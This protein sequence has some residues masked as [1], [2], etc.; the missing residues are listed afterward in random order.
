MTT[1]R[2]G[3]T[4]VEALVALFV[5]AIGMI[6]LM[7][8]FP[9][10]A[11]QMGQAL[12]D[13]RSS[14]LAVQADAKV[15]TYWRGLLDGTLT[16]SGT[17]T[18]MT[19]FSNPGNGN[20]AVGSNAPPTIL[21]S[22]PGNIEPSYPVFLD[23]IGVSAW[24][25]NLQYV[26]KV[27]QLAQLPRRTFAAW[28]FS[29]SSSTASVVR[30]AGL[31]DDLSYGDGGVATLTDP[32]SG[33]NLTP[34]IERQGRYNWLA[35]VQRPDNSNPGVA[36]LKI[37]VFDG[38]APGY[39]A[40][41]SETVYNKANNTGNLDVWVTPGSTSLTLFYSGARPAVTKGRWIMDAT[42][43]DANNTTLVMTGG[44]VQNPTTGGPYNLNLRNANFY[45]VV[46]VND[47]TPNQLDIEIQTPF[48]LSRDPQGNSSQNALPYSAT[49]VV[50][51]GV[52]EVFDR[53]LL[54][55]K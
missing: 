37:V 26:D 46:S 33:T 44:T 8:L 7:T 18:L 6:C 42:L 53:P 2:P 21:A 30:L 45:R 19:S 52:A 14:Q 55:Q 3:L 43:S 12:K 9:L 1:S 25:G 51:N 38:R 15:R 50:L 39:P 35:V 17:P 28:N 31:L 22:S 48:K 41:G 29:S 34:A 5:A 40:P 16:D 36:E 24:N 20:G 13:E 27:A 47:E 10:G 49:I 23:A 54:T 32:N 4:L 11:L